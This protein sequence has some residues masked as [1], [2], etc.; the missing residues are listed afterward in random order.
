MPA[1]FLPFELQT[2][3]PRTADHLLSN[4]R[5]IIEAAVATG[6]LFL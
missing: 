1:I 6:E 4:W 2:R 5:K 3:S